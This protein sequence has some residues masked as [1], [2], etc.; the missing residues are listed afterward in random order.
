MVA[1][2]LPSRRRSLF[3]PL[4]ILAFIVGSFFFL[5]ILLVG[6]FT[7]RESISFSSKP[8]RVIKIEGTI[9]DSLET[10]H[11]IERVQFDKDVKAVVLRIDSPGGAVGPSQEIYQQV[12]KLKKVKPVVV[13]MGTVAASGG[14][15]I[16]SAASKI[17]ASPGTVTGS[18]GVIIQ[19]LG[20]QGV[21]DKLAVEERTI[22]SGKYKDAGNPFRRMED[23]ERAYLQEISDNMYGQFVRDVAANRGIA[24]DKAFEIAQGKIYTGLMAKELG[25]VDELGNIYAAIDL[26]IN[27]AGLPADS[28]VEWPRKPDFFERLA[29]SEQ[30]SLLLNYLRGKM[31]LQSFP[32]ALMPSMQAK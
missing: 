1:E 22:K 18:I 15:Y 23:F 26:A 3:W 8:V 7:G 25:L 16:S 2:A 6:L 19:N 24:E 28:G 10:L 32:L 5:L 20:M 17:V 14:Y 30:A 9:L 21:L 12:L 11:E 31:S 27:L 4:S 13:S 29:E